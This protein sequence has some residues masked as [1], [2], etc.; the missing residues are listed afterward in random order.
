MTTFAADA[1]REAETARRNA[2]KAQEIA[3]RYQNR[4]HP[5]IRSFFGGAPPSPA[6][7]GGSGEGTV[8]LSI[9]ASDFEGAS[10]PPSPPNLFQPTSA[11]TTATP[12]RPRPPRIWTHREQAFDGD[13]EDGEEVAAGLSRGTLKGT[14]CVD[15]DSAADRTEEEEVTGG[16]QE[17]QPRTVPRRAVHTPISL[18]DRIAQNHAQEILELTHELERTNRALKETRRMHEESEAALSS[19]KAKNRSLEEQNRKLLLE[20]EHERQRATEE[21]SDLKQQLAQERRNV[22]EANEDA[23]L[24]VDLAKSSDEARNQVEEELVEALEELRMWKEGKRHLADSNGNGN[25]ISL[26]GGKLVLTT[27]PKRH[28]RFAD[29]PRSAEQQPHL[30]HQLEVEKEGSTEFETPGGTHRPS[31]SIVAAGRQVLRRNKA[32]S[33]EEAILMLEMTPSKSAELRE[34]LRQRLTE[35]G[36]DSSPQLRSLPGSP[37]RACS[38]AAAPAVA[39]ATKKKLDECLTATKL[40]QTSGKKLDLDGY[41]WRDQH[42]QVNITKASALPYTEI[43]LDA[44]TRQYCQNVEVGTSIISSLVGSGGNP[45]ESLT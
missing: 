14:G 32:S 21:V 10:P 18:A 42:L 15:G 34:R 22:Q 3:R 8:G 35:L 36:E 31:R 20:L 26:G 40:L 41:W 13:D 30:Q 7:N 44:M 29:E 9:L 43:Q 28:V 5:K 6:T 11:T 23:N 27:T 37:T 33:P 4:S 38:D 16:Q 2:R 45:L 39:A 24:A 12:T 25:A 17:G 1:A 19:L